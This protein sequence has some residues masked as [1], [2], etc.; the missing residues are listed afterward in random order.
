M[1][2]KPQF[3]SFLFF[4]LLLLLPAASYSSFA[5]NEEEE[6]DKISRSMFPDAFLFGTSTSAYQIEGA[7]LEDGKTL[8]NWDVFTHI[9]GN[10]EN[11]DNGDVADDDYHRYMYDIEVMESIGVN[12]YRF[13]ISWSRILPSG[14]VGG[15]NPYGI[16][17]YNKI[18][19]NLLLK[20]IEPFVTINHHDIPQELEERYEGWLNPLMQEDFVHLA[21]TCFENFGDR[22]KYWITIN[23]PNLLADMA[24][25]RGW[26]P[27]ARC[28]EPFGNCSA[29]NSDVE[30]L[31]AVHNMLLS[32]A[33]AAK[34]YHQQFK[35]KQ[36]GSIGIVAN[37]FMYEPFRD[38]ENDRQAV[39]RK[40]AFDVA[41]IFDPLIY[42]D[43]PLEMRKY[44]GKELPKFSQEETQLVK[45][46]LDFI[47]INHYSSLY[48]MDCLHFPCT[49]IY[50]R[51][52]A[53]YVGVT[54]ERDGKLIGER[55]G[56]PRF[57]VVPRGMEKIMDYVKRRYPTMPIFCD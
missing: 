10:I 52:I 14:K 41:W 33:R 5:E 27:P 55:T 17:F 2:T 24:Y 4:S 57:F 36:G 34:L 22:V 53:G 20:G 46:S 40:L 35:A 31:I 38:N 12:A 3:F 11:G 44:D 48:A 7:Y 54:G 42:G 26:Y 50:D 9:P 28:S 39:R 51:A 37:A 13:S 8:N 32:H 45:G 15:V 23:E 43:Y 49:A 29:G 19:D 1:K 25:L 16:R 18:I 56:M 47:G 21:K 30:P 6:E